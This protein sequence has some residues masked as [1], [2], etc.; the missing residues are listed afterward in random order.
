MARKLF[1]DVY[2]RGSKDLQIYR[3]PL[4]WHKV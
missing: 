1:L 2:N 4:D 3:K